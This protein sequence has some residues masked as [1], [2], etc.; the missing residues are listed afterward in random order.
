MAVSLC[1]YMNYFT[2]NAHSMQ[3]NFTFYGHGEKTAQKNRKKLRKK[4]KKSGIEVQFV[5]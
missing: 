3:E 1:K 5:V 4:T 2:T